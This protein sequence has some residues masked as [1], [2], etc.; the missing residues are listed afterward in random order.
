MVCSSGKFVV[1]VVDAKVLVK[2]HVHQAVI[3]PPTVRMDNALDVCLAPDNGLRG[4]LGGVRNDLCVYA[5]IPLEQAKDDGFARCALP[6]LAAHTPGAKAGFIC[7]QFATKGRTGRAPLSHALP[8]AQVDRVDRA[9]RNTAQ[10]R[11]FGRRQI[12]SKV[13][14]N[15]AKFRL[16]DFRTP[17]VSVFA[18]IS[19]R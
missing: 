19:R 14:R 9:H 10:R 18:S 2:A 12:K 7:F 13:A 8:D 6:P 16:T 5:S 4:V 1:A 3:A 15:Q 11:A 17:E